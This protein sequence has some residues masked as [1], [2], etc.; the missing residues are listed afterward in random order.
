MLCLNALSAFAANK[1]T[2]ELVPSVWAAW[3]RGNVVVNGQNAEVAR[4]WDNYSEDLAFGGSLELVLRNKK[5]I[6]LG[7]VDYFDNISSDVMVG[8]QPATL[9]TSEIIGCLAIGYPLARPS[10]KMTADFLVGLQ[11]LRMDNELKQ[12]GVGSQSARTDIFD[13]VIML[14]IKMLLTS[15]LYLHVPLAVGGPYLGESELVY[16]VGAQLLFN[17]TDKFD[18]RAG[19]RISGYDYEEDA[20]NQWDFYQ[21]GFTLGFGVIF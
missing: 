12:S 13:T 16:D 5:M 8:S 11:G 3:L 18:L 19:Y 4:D 6:L 1:E 7:S 2:I 21:Q 14:R 20:N 10:A 9:E 15:R 17:V